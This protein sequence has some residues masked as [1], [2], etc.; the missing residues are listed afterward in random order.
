VTVGILRIIGA[1]LINIHGQQDHQMLSNVEAHR[2][3]LDSFGSHAA[4]LE[5]YQTVYENM[6]KIGNALRAAKTDEKEKARQIDILQFQINELSSANLKPG[7]DIALAERREVIRNSASLSLYLDK[8]YTSLAGNDDLPGVLAMLDE[9]AE[10]LLKTEYYLKELFNSSS[11]LLDLRYEIEEIARSV[12]DNAENLEYNPREQ[13]DI[14]ERLDLINRLKKKY[15]TTIDEMLSYLNSSIKQLDDIETS[16]QRIE[17]MMLEYSQLEK[18]ALTNAAALT[19]ARKDAAKRF[20][21]AVEQVLRDLDMPHTKMEIPF[22][23]KEPGPYGC[24]DLEFCLAVNPGEESKPMVKCASGGE[25]SRI[26]LAIKSVI[27]GK[28]DI[29]TLIFDEIDNGISGRAAEKVGRKL[30]QVATERQ[31]ICV[32]HLAQVASYSDHHLMIEKSVEG[33]RTYTVVTPLD[34]SQRILEL[35]RII[36]GEKITEQ[37]IGNAKKMI[38]ESAN[39]INH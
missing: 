39:V 10:A 21:K 30:K 31:V 29:H 9:A 2:V 26:M 19:K 18:I 34:G 32:T 1:M 33:G 38:E 3:F 12:S 35:A 6:T 13:D 17:Q 11:R 37:A 5:S 23:E 20:T 7:E 36:S 4:L 28:H 24:D 25:M 14:E 27:S 8:C 22:Q 16:E 15:G